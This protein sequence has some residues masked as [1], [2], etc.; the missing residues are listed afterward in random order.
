MAI[1]AN[2]P[3]ATSTFNLIRVLPGAAGQFVNFSFYDAGDAASSGT[4]K[5]TPPA[6]GLGSVKTTPF[7]GK[8]SATGGNAGAG[9]TSSTC[10]FTITNANNNGKVETMTIPI[11]SDYNCNYASMGGCWYTVTISFNGGS[12]VH[13]V[14]TWD[15]Q[16]VGDPV[17]LV[18]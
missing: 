10:S 7:P 2:A 9:T 15:A 18:K 5:V 8:C 3:G 13:D 12:A 16:V 17:R 11:P 1:F 4:V 14:T 6:D